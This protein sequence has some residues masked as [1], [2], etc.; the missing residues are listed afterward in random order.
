[1]WKSTLS[2]RTEAVPS[3]SNTC[4]C[5]THVLFIPFV[6]VFA[7]ILCFNEKVVCVSSNT[8]SFVL[9]SY[10]IILFEYDLLPV[11]IISTS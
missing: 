8:F 4:A 1:M 11:H 9:L 6:S 5:I 2:D 7:G 3:L 10:I